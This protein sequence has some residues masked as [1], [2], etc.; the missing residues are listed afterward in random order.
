MVSSSWLPAGCVRQPAG[1]SLAWRTAALAFPAG[2]D[3]SGGAVA[4]AV[5]PGAFAVGTVVFAALLPEDP[6]AA[7]SN[8][9]VIESDGARR[10][11]RI[12]RRWQGGR[13]GAR[14]AM[15]RSRASLFS[16]CRATPPPS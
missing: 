15:A 4:G 7:S 14:A 8:V 12:G 16:S 5:D 3:G 6:Q 11:L 9:A 13:E 10:H 1:K 2:L